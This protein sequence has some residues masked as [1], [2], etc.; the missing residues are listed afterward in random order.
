MKSVIDSNFAMWEEKEN[1]LLTEFLYRT[2]SAA[3]RYKKYQYYLSDSIIIHILISF[4]DQYK[5]DL[6]KGYNVRIDSIWPLK[7][8]LT[9]P[10]EI[11][12]KRR[13]DFVRDALE[14]L[15]YKTHLPSLKKHT[16]E[17]VAR[18]KN[19]NAPLMLK[20]QLLCLCDKGAISD[21]DRKKYREMI[22]N[23]I[24]EEKTRHESFFEHDS[25]HNFD[26]GY[27][28]IP[29][30]VRA[31][32]GDTIVLK[33]IM[34]LAKDNGVYSLSDFIFYGTLIWSQPVINEFLRLLGM[35]VP[36]CNLFKTDP[37]ETL[38]RHF[39]EPKYQ[40]CRSLQDSIIMALAR[41]HP[42]DLMFSNFYATSRRNADFC[43]PELQE[44][45]FIDFAKWIKKNY[46]YDLKYQGFKPYFKKDV[47][48]D[49]SAIKELC[50]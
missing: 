25:V 18:L 26:F 19:C 24:N 31:N 23:R 13:K 38:N 4:L 41:H 22:N 2:A 47:S 40:T 12:V 50:K 43:K 21:E 44:I 9:E 1:E 20:L 28:P 39:A 42:D 29:L 34:S 10:G 46:N 33:N 37:Y 45:Y 5:Y 11:E 15:I 36:L 30:W 17:I 6:H 35:D 14:L 48:K 49:Q 8:P 7:E 27:Q 16:S 3:T 32:L